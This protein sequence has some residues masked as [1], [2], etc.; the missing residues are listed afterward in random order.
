MMAAQKLREMNLILAVDGSEH[1]TAAA[2]LVRE[3]PLSRDSSIT[4]LAVLVPRDASNHASLEQALAEAKEILGEDNPSVRTELLTGYPAEQISEYAAKLV[5]DLIVLGAKGRRA[6]LGILLGGVVQQI[7]EY[8]DD[9]VLVVRAPFE[10]IQRILL[11]TDGSAHS[12]YAAS[13]LGKF[14]IP[15]LA[16]V[17]VLH[18]LPPMP[19]PALIARS[20]PAGSETMAPVPSYETEE[21]LARQAEEEERNGELL[22]VDTVND[23]SNY[24]I[25]AK[26]VLLRGDAA[27]EIIQYANEHQVNLIVAGSRG[28]SQMRRLLLGSL[29]RKLVHYA[30]C[31]VL[32]VKGGSHGVP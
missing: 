14:P 24:G 6:T 29:S 31:S 26:S 28:L 9:P 32:I 5:P 3:L 13:Y 2:R 30:G 23:L 16:E 15:D 17:H 21:I 7:V 4:V 18:V 8:A 10:G 25:E 20:W 11:V 19:S 12:R 1:S 22:L 27:T